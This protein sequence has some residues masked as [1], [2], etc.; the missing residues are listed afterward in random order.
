MPTPLATAELA[1]LFETREL[2]L[3]RGL[4]VLAAWVILNLVVSGYYLTKADRRY[5][6]FYFHGMN[7]SWGLV[8]AC[9]ACWGI[10]HLHFVAP[11]GLQAAELLQTQLFNEN[12][13]LL[14]AGLD[15]AYIMTG[16]YLRALAHTPGQTRPARLLGFGKSLWVQGG[17]LLVFDAAMWSLLHWLSRDWWRLLV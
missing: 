10:L 13:F 8:N 12:L 15:V 17:F 7:V 11:K 16:A 1:A 4:A 3:G 6:P 14:N 5:E 2:V 9:L